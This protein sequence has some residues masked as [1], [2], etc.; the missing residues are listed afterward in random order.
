MTNKEKQLRQRLA[1]IYQQIELLRRYPEE[2]Q[3]AL[4]KK[5]TDE[6]LDRTLDEA[7]DIRRKIHEING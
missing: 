4:G 3:K 2:F 7:N 6:W 1:L 5:G